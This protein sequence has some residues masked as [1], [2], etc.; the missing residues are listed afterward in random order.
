MALFQVFGLH[1]TALSVNHSVLASTTCNFYPSR[2]TIQFLFLPAL[3]LLLGQL[4]CLVLALRLVHLWLRRAS[5]DAFAHSL[6]HARR[7]QDRLVGVVKTG[8]TQVVTWSLG[9]IAIWLA[10]I[11]LWHVFALAT[12]LQAMFV[13]TTGLLS[14]EVL[15]SMVF[16]PLNQ[17]H[18]RRHAEAHEEEKQMSVEK[19]ISVR[20]S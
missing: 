18:R 19:F 11:A 4:A 20:R 9:L 7:H 12:A 6:V 1:Q 15:G 10:S 2:N 17:Y 8:G 16:A 5:P 14:R 3:V 13:A